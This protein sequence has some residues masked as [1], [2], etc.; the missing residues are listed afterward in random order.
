MEWRSAERPR[1]KISSEIVLSAVQNSANSVT[2]TTPNKTKANI[3]K[4]IFHRVIT[5]CSWHCLVLFYSASAFAL[6]LI[7]FDY[8]NQNAPFK[9]G[10][11]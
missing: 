10:E 11:T 3:S 8:F 5:S 2:H 1:Y 9:G 4:G 7:N 6:F